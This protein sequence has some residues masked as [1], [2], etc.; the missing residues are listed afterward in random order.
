[1]LIYIYKKLLRAQ[2]RVLKKALKSCYKFKYCTHGG[3]TLH[4]GG[5][6]SVC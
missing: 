6:L 4:M 5:Y 2:S 1:M 3:H